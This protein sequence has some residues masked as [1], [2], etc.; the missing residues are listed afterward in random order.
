MGGPAAR[1]PESPRAEPWNSLGSPA[2]GV[3]C[4]H[5]YTSSPWTLR[6]LAE[7]IARAGYSV[8]LPLLAGH[9]G[10]GS[11][12]EQR[13]SDWTTQVEARYLALAERCEKVVVLGLSVGGG[14]ACWLAA[15]YPE[16]SALILVNP[17]VRGAEAP[18]L[19]GLERMLA[20][21]AR[22]LPPSRP[23]I[24]DGRVRLPADEG[25]PIRPLLSIFAGL[26]GLE[27]ERIRAPILLFSSRVDHIVDAA[28]G[29][30][31][32]ARVGGP[33][34]RV[35]L[36]RSYHVATVDHDRGEITAR[37]L[38]LLKAISA[39]KSVAGP[40]YRFGYGTSEHASRFVREHLDAAGWSPTHGDDWT[41]FW[42]SSTPPAAVYDRLTRGRFVNH[43]P[44]ISALTRKDSLSWALERERSSRPRG[45]SRA[46]IHPTTWVMPDD[47]A[48][49]QVAASRS[50]GAIWIRKPAASSNGRGIRLFT[51]PARLKARSGVV[52][53]RYLSRPHLLDGY[54]YSLRCYVA[55]TA[56]DPVQAWLFDDGFVKFTSRPYSRASDTLSDRVMH[57]T[58]PAVQK[59][60]RAVP[61]SARNLTH[62]GYRE[63]LRAAGL[64]DEA[65][66]QRIGSLV[67]DAV[68]AGRPFIEH[69]SAA[70][71]PTVHGRPFELL[72]LDIMVDSRLRPWLIECNLSPSLG[73]EADE[74][75][76]SAQMECALKRRLVGELLALA[77]LLP[78]SSSHGGFRRIP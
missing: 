3:L 27:L 58:N 38:A 66:F 54:K 57:L 37:T 53:Q 22:R 77:G 62:R 73:V 70:Q 72:G 13:W 65:L 40:H 4:L 39:E 32:S 2:L 25:T 14:L 43:V 23:D 11:L 69:R 50:P 20:A 17:A 10:E 63:R 26:N 74:S 30:H 68:R 24:A 44:G 21:G 61:T 75:T 41:L 19:A 51:D 59:R 56:V 9:G 7:A 28:Q 16:L 71:L 31:L 33:V 46:S 45:V 29:E 34:H 76:P 6:A 36:D 49:F 67:A 35:W 12:D 42:S 1:E 5:G 48:A 60:N 8:D 78:A 47:H 55:F 64:D 52:V 18:V 15:R